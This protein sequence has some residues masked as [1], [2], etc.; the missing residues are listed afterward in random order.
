MSADCCT[1]PGQ[2][3]LSA[4]E[5]LTALLSRA[6][7][8]TEQETLP[9][10]GALGRV[11]AQDVISPVAVPGH[12]NSAMDGYAMRAADAASGPLPVAQRIPAGVWPA[13]LAAGTAARIFTGAPI[14]PG[15]DAV[16]MQEV[17]QER[18]G[19]VS[20]AAGVNPGDHIRRAGEDIAAGAVVLARGARLTPQAL[21]LA[22]SV[23]CAALPLWRRLRV[24]L[25]TTGDE[26]AEPGR[27][28]AP[29]QIYNSNRAVLG[30]LLHSLGCEVLD[31]GVVPDSAAATRAALLDAAARADVI[32]TSG[33]VSVGEEDHVKRE[34][35]ALGELALWRVRI[36]PGK[37]LACGRVGAADVIGLP[38]NPVSVLVTFLLFARPFLLARMGAAV[39][40]ALPRGFAVRAAFER[41]KADSRRDF[42]RAR[43]LADTAGGWQAEPYRNPSSGVLSS[44]VWADGLLVVPEGCTVARGDTLAFIPFSELLS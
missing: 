9:L 42:L 26:L 19:Q 39:A 5:A 37:P 16:V 22:A 12:D 27:P 6:R 18:G 24:A 31:L 36:K 38:G 1:P 28:L 15:A 21:G 17:C 11:L 10:N 20:I 35:E 44:A 25:F 4:E 34:V 13:P 30:A 43:L 41:R 33:G 2:S 29:G 32:L 7:P 8:V 3:L 40:P 14:P 23:G